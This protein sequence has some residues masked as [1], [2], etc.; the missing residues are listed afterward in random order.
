MKIK[1][2]LSTAAC[3]C[4]LFSGA[5]LLAVAAY[6]L[7]NFHVS[8]LSRDQWHMYAQ[9]FDEGLL[10]TSMS[11]VSGHRHLFAFSFFS[12]D[13]HF[14]GGLNHFLVAVTWLLNTA[15]L[16]LL[17]REIWRYAPLALWLAGSVIFV[18]WWLINLA[19]LGWGFNG[20][21]N[22][23][24][25]VPSI[26]G[27]Y[28]LSLAVQQF[29][30]T[31]ITMA[32][33]CG[34][35]ATLSFGNGAVIWPAGLLLL[36]GLRAQVHVY[37][38]WL[39]AS[40]IGI[41]LYLLLPGADA[42]NST[43]LFN[44][45]YTLRY[46]FEQLGGPLWHLVRSVP[47]FNNP[48]SLLLARLLGYVIGAVSLIYLARAVLGRRLHGEDYSSLA[49]LACAL[50][51]TGW[52]SL[53]LLTITRPAGMLDIT[54]D[55]FQIWALLMWLGLLIGLWQWRP[56][57][58][59]LL[60]LV[61]VFPLAALPSQLDWGARLAEYHNRTAQSLLPW[62][63]EL[64]LAA[65]AERALHWNWQQKIAPMQQVLAR[66]HV[67]QKNL[68]L[69]IPNQA[70][71][72]KVDNL[73][74]CTQLF[75]RSR[76]LPITEKELWPALMDAPSLRV[77]WRLF[78]QYPW[79][80]ADSVALLDGDRKIIGKALPIRHSLLPRVSGM[81]HG[82]YNLYGLTK[83]ESAPEF[84]IVFRSGSPHCEIEV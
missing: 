36:W 33:V 35:V 65:D 58:L 26:Y 50:Q 12:L 60:P 4:W 48:Q 84:L 78:A 82:G 13:W 18:G 62:M 72:A 2:L 81:R 1:S 42:V 66:A 29:S 76:L 3:A 14:F 28:F 44:G 52:G 79:D 20:L 32:A 25:I 57:R 39:V 70:L 16:G 75:T 30:S 6:Y 7:F 38:L 71:G 77:G 54:I 21:N 15:L 67:E 43:L 56:A 73:P 34:V 27:L 83:G 41:A 49:V 64:P 68:Y 24:S 19:L 11:T 23:L 37:G 69:L 22:Y 9:L 59:V 45:W 74:A 40:A 55:R 8:P 46:P 31:K 47:L 61:A 17:V 80:V 53:L 51:L 10:A 5:V 63:L